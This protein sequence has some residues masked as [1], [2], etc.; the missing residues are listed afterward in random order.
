M[1]PFTHS[2]TDYTAPLQLVFV[3]IWGHSHV[4]STHG[5][6]YFVSFVNAFSGY[7][8]LYLISHKSQ[9]TSMF[10]QFKTLKENQ[11]GYSIKTL[12]SD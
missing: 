7:T 2:H 8:W 3:D 10:L 6:L 11:A 9:A 1:L 12:Q 5:S 4:A